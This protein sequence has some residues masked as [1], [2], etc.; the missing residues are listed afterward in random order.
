MIYKLVVTVVT[1][2]TIPWPKKSPTGP[3]D[4][5]PPAASARCSP[6]SPQALPGLAGYANDEPLSNV[7]E[8]QGLVNV[9]IEHHQTLRDV[10][11][12]R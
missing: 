7:E 10:I 2:V 1:H 8:Y 3:F 12:N 6:S 4:R 9:P 11:S 5:T